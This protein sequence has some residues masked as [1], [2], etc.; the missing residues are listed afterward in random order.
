MWDHSTPTPHLRGLC[1]LKPWRCD[2]SLQDRR[3]EGRHNHELDGIPIRAAR[4]M[5]PRSAKLRVA[6]LF[7]MVLLLVTAVLLRPH[8]R[9]GSLLIYSRLTGRLCAIT[10]SDLVQ[11]CNTKFTLALSKL[12]LSRQ[13]DETYL[14][15]SDVDASTPRNYKLTAPCATQFIIH[16]GN[17]GTSFGLDDGHVYV[18]Q[19]KDT[20][21]PSAFAD[22]YGWHTGES[23]QVCRVAISHQYRRLMLTGGGGE[24]Y[25]IALR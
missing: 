3:L 22:R 13:A 17:S 5:I 18:I 7:C 2:R 21:E 16:V 10:W 25:A 12:G 15:W 11:P 19:P 1:V 20:A 9:N 23:I 24:A 6:I 4:T 8:V 14:Y